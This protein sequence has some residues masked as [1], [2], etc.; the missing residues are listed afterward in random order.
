MSSDLLPEPTHGLQN[1]RLIHPVLFMLDKT[2]SQCNK[3][4]TDWGC[5]NKGY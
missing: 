4:S 3:T 5:L 1:T 2:W